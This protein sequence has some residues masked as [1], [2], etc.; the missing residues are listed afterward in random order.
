MIRAIKRYFALGDYVN[1]LSLELVRRF[2][3]KS[4]YS[5]EHVTQTVERGGYDKTYL[6]YAHAAFC[7]RD[8]FDSYYGSMNLKCTFDGLREP[9]GKR[10]LGGRTDF[11][12]AT[13]IRRAKG[14]S[15]AG[16]PFRTEESG[17][18]D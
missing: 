11:D 6:A 18:A 4:L 15:A 2:G 14:T 12:A 17:D 9:I 5:L 16:G 8:D 3:M 13:V 7:S 1:R 10:F